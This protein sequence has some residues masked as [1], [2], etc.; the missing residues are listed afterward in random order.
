MKLL[1][2][3]VVATWAVRVRRAVA[4]VCEGRLQGHTCMAY[5]ADEVL[6]A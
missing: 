2:N 4:E 3:A 1:V 6:V 5:V